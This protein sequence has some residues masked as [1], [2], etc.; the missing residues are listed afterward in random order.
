MFYVCCMD[1]IELKFKKVEFHSSF[2]WHTHKDWVHACN[3]LCPSSSPWWYP[4]LGTTMWIFHMVQSGHQHAKSRLSIGWCELATCCFRKPVPWLHL[5]PFMVHIII[6]LE[7]R[8]VAYL[9]C[10]FP[11]LSNALLQ[12]DGT[13]SLPLCDL[14]DQRMSLGSWTT[15]LIYCPIFSSDDTCD[16]DHQ[17][18][19]YPLLFSPILVTLLQLRIW[20]CACIFAC[21]PSLVA[22]S[23]LSWMGSW[24]AK[25]VKPS[26]AWGIMSESQF[27]F[28]QRC[29][30]KINHIVFGSTY[31]LGMSFGHVIDL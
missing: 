13:C 10:Q 30:D 23:R 20:T 18:L 28:L 3:S 12:V 19:H 27:W 7:W 31:P 8:I 5:N 29:N 11:V 14:H 2:V 26:A 15:I 4:F 24:G 9:D 6:I 25:S 17:W 1:N 16:P 21:T 22:L